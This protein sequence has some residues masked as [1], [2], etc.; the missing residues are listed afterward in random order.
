LLT[1]EKLKGVVHKKGMTRTNVALLCV[2]AAG[3]LNVT[4]GQAKQFAVDAGVKKAKDINFSSLFASA[5]DKVFK[6]P[7]GWELTDVGR[8]HVAT[9]SAEVLAS[10]PAAAEA[11]TLRA[12]LSKIKN[13]EARAFVTEAIVCAEQS[14]FR[15]A[16]VLSWSGAVST[17]QHEVMLNH[18]AAF[19]AEATRRDQKWKAAK[20]ADDLGRMKEAAFLEVCEAISMYGKNVKQ[21]LELCLKLRNGCGHPNSLKIASNKVA[22]HLEVLALN[23]FSNFA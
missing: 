9:L 1:L 22:A 20:T 2:G 17:L 4:T 5:K 19:N 6:T 12:L 7:S 10:S 18:L 14:L 11:K 13:D 23:V 8:A 3:G 21:E 16:V 15:A